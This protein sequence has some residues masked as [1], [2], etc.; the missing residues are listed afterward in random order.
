MTTG[1]SPGLLDELAENRAAFRAT[2][3]DITEQE[4]REQ[5]EIREAAERRREANEAQ[6]KALDERAA[7]NEKAREDPNAKNE[8]LNRR[9]GGERTMNFGPG[10]DELDEAADAQQSTQPAPSQQTT[11]PT[12]LP[13]SESVHPSLA[14]HRRPRRDE[15]DDEDF[16]NRDWF[17]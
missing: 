16:A 17:V 4:Q 15:D 14:K 6:S 13:A 12:P 3:A 2:A 11:V 5:R 9:D 1:P 8:W 7:A 10:A